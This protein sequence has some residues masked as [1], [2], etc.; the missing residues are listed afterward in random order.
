MTN[1]QRT[2]MIGLQSCLVVFTT[3]AVA[4]RATRTLQIDFRFFKT[5]CVF[6]EPAKPEDGD[7]FAVRGSANSDTDPNVDSAWQ[8]Y[9]RFEI[10]RAKR[11]QT[12]A[13]VA[14]RTIMRQQN[15]AIFDSCLTEHESIELWVKP[16]DPN[17]APDER[18]A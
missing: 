17:G 18:A 11:P 16:K 1:I 7:F 2:E 3:P 6:S 4:I 14:H 9:L 10:R 5:K 15:S 12:D 8:S 13:T